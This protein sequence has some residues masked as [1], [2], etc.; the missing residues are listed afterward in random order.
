[1]GLGVGGSE[2]GGL[3]WGVEGVWGLEVEDQY[4]VQKSSSNKPSQSDQMFS[5]AGNESQAPFHPDL[6]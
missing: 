6:V 4:R 1:M 2:V 5:H 3:K